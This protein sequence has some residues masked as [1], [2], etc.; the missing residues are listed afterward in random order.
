MTAD[1]VVYSFQQNSDPKVYVNAASVFTGVLDKSGVK[2]IDDQTVQFN[3]EAP[4]GNFP[5]LISS[6]NYN[7][8]IVKNG[9]DYAKWQ[10]DFLGTGA[11]KLQ[12]YHANDGATFVP[13][14]NWWGGKVL[15][16]K[17]EH[18]VLSRPGPADHRA[19]RRRRGHRQPDRAVR[20]RGR[21]E[22]SRLH[23]VGQQVVAA[24]RALD[25]KRQVALE[26]QARAPGHGAVAQSPGDRPGIVQGLCPARQRYAVCADVPIDQHHGAAAG[27][28]HPQGQAADVAGRPPQRVHDRPVHRELPGDVGLRDHHQ[29]GAARRSAS[30]STCTSTTR[31]PTTR[32]TGC[33]AR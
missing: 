18:I 20:R 17:L 8:I 31:A 19:D 1:D 3:L 22:Q 12:A 4:N 14:P 9:T 33:R 24:P 32:I 13:N 15:P 26:Q 6:D 21:A 30:T 10:K 25:A 5:Y 7:M 16:A 23:P 29:A 28:G 11:F 27:A 2:K